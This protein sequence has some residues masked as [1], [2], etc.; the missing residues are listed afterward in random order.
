MLAS[1]VEA[2]TIATRTTG[3]AGAPHKNFFNRDG[4]ASFCTDTLSVPTQ[5]TSALTRK[6]RRALRR[7][8]SVAFTL[9]AT[10]T[11]A[12]GNTGKATR[13]ARVRRGR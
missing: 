3:V 9:K 13:K 1:S 2:S 12:A 5:T 8:R 11:D 4:L 7:S 10:A 6:A